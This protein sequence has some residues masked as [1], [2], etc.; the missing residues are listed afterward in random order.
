[1]WPWLV[2]AVAALLVAG[3]GG[4]TLQQQGAQLPGQASASDS[5]S[6]TLDVARVLI[7]DEELRRPGALATITGWPIEAR[8]L[9]VHALIDERTFLVGPDDAATLVVIVP[10]PAG[11]DVTLPD[12]VDDLVSMLGYLRQASS[13]PA[14]MSQ[15]A[16]DAIRSSGVFL[17]AE[18]VRVLS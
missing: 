16:I 13:Q 14:G 3:W 9:R 5:P 2:A 10:Q 6:S 11:D 12:E 1:M 17:E 18:V 7:T 4:F 15:G 8:A